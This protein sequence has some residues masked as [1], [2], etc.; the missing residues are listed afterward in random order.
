MVAVLEGNR[1][2]RVC[3]YAIVGLRTT[4]DIV[5]RDVNMTTIDKTHDT[6]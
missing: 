3:E 1:P 5:M 4:F 6:V 2:N